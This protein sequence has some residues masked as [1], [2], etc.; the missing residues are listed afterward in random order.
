[1]NKLLSKIRTSRFFLLTVLSIFLSQTVIASDAAF[2]RINKNGLLTVGMS[3]EQPPY[4]FVTNSENI[5]GHDVELADA[6]AN[7]MDVKVK[8]MLMP[9]ADLLE[10]LENNKIDMII[11]GFASSEQ[12]RQKVTFVGPYVLAGKSLLLTKETLNRIRESTGFNHKDIRLL[13]LKN[14][15]SMTLAKERLAKASLKPVE[16][17]EDALLALRAGKADALVADLTICEL[18]V[19]RDTASELTT[20]KKP[21]AIEE[22]NIAINKGEIQLESAARAH[23]LTL[24]NSGQLEKLH[25]R[26]F[27]NGGWLD[28]L[29]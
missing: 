11:S 24:K 23:L 7:L 26:W 2:A 15:T 27:K 12:R 10:A 9:F 19:I 4:N 14:S 6:L 8:I 20:L 5:V 3:G 1:M 13:A 22:I 18:G 16:H 17:Y 21:L 25:Q 29:P 28:L